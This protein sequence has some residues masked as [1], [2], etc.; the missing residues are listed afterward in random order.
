MKKTIAILLVLFS[1]ATSAQRLSCNANG[2]VFNSENKAVP[3]NEVRTLLSDNYEAFELYN[4]GRDK[5]TMGSV[6]LLGGLG[7]IAANFVIAATTDNTTSSSGTVKSE[8]A[9]AT[10][11]I[12]GG[13]M[14]VAAIPIKIGFSKK[15]K[16]SVELYNKNLADNYKPAQKWT[17]L[18]SN[19]QFGFRVEF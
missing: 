9:D 13:V 1:L 4:A 6:F 8:R 19:Q 2:T 3:P 15:I 17:L 12:I 5:K 16:K 18:A 11:G 10:L 7:L 14:M